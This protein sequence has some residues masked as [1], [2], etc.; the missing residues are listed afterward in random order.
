MNLALRPI[1]GIFFLGGGYCKCFSYFNLR[2]NIYTNTY[3]DYADTDL[4][5][6]NDNTTWTTIFNNT[7]NKDIDN[8]PESDIHDKLYRSWFYYN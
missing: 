6:I 3:D 2:R 7:N 5:I 8:E 1:R 4:I